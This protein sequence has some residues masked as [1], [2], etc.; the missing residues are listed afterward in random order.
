LLLVAVLVDG[1]RAVAAV[2][3]VYLQELNPYQMDRHFL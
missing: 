1:I 3:V 2:L